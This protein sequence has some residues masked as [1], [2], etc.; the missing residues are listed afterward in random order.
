MPNVLLKSDKIYT[1]REFERELIGKIRG[2]QMGTV[3]G[4]YDEKI[5]K[6]VGS[7]DFLQQLARAKIFAGLTA[8]NKIDNTW[9]IYTPLEE[10]YKLLM[11]LKSEKISMSF[12]QDL[13]QFYHN[14]PQGRFSEG[15]LHLLR[16]NLK[17][18]LLKDTAKKN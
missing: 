2:N 18:S 16:Y 13:A 7:G 8:K 1:I 9:E 15:D 14:F 10:S 12:L 6:I 5:A 4:D 11:Q 3:S 17:G